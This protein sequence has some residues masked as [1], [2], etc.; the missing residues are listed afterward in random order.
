MPPPPRCANGIA[1]AAA[2]AAAWVH[3]CVYVR[4]LIE[5]ARV[6]RRGF[7]WAAWCVSFFGGLILLQGVGRMDV[8]RAI[9]CTGVGGGEFARRWVH[10]R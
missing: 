9:F 10:R 3:V 7:I 2:A 8:G 6:I 1:S 5:G 4:E